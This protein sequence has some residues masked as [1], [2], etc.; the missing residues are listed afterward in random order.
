MCHV[1]V[2]YSERSASVGLWCVATGR[3]GGVPRCVCSGQVCSG[4]VTI[5]EHVECRNT[6]GCLCA[7][8]SSGGQVWR[9][10]AAEHVHLTG[11]QYWE[12]VGGG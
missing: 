11:T 9:A 3:G 4:C 8:R 5:Q 2:I 10:A 7:T 6:F 1:G 12:A